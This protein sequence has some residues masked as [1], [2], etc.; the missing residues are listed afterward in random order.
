LGVASS[1]DRTLYHVDPTGM[2]HSM[3]AGILNITP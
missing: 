2:D 1:E 3:T